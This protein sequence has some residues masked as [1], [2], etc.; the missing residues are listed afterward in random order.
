LDGGRPDT[1]SRFKANGDSIC[2]DTT[3]LIRVLGRKTGMR[4]SDTSSYAYIRMGKTAMPALDKPDS[5]WF[6]GRFCFTFSDATPGAH[7]QYTLDGSDPAA[8][9]IHAH[10]GDS[11]CVDR[12]VAVRLIAEAPNSIPSD[13]N[14]YRYFRMDTAAAPVS[15]RAD[16]TWFRDTLCLVLSSATPGAVIHYTVDGSRPDTA[17]PVAPAGGFCVDRSSQVRAIAVLKHWIDSPVSAYTYAKMGIL[18]PPAATPSDSSGFPGSLC[19]HF[20]TNADGAALRYSLDGSDPSGSSLVM[21]MSDSLCFDSTVAIRARAE[22]THW[23]PSP[24]AA[25]TY[26]RM[27]QVARPTA[28]RSDSTWFADTLCV[29]FAIATDSATLHYLLGPGRTDT[30]SLLIAPGQNLCLDRGAVVRV[31]GTRPG[32]L[33]S[34]ELTLRFFKMDTAAVPTADPGDSTWFAGRQCIRLSTSTAGAGIRYTVD[35]G[36]PAVSGRAL[37]SGDTVCIEDTATLRV[38]ARGPNRVD[39]RE[40]VFHYLRMRKVATPS[41]DRRD[42]TFFA[43]TVCVRFGTAT[44]GAT[45]RYT[46]DGSAPDTA[47]PV[48]AGGGPLCVDRT[49]V[50][51]VIGTKEHWIPSDPMAIR[52]LKMDTVARPVPEPGDSTYFSPSLCVKWTVATPGAVI[53]VTTDGA[54]PDSSSRLLASGDTLCLDRTATLRAAGAKPDWIASPE[55]SAAFLRMQRAAK[56]AADQPDSLYFPDRVCIRFT[57]A[58]AGTRIRYALDG[59]RADTSGLS[60]ANGDSVC[61]ERS[62]RIE[63]VAERKN[64]LAS[65]ALSLNVFRMETA[66]IPVAGVPDSTWFR[67]RICV[68]WT[69]ATPGAAITVR[70]AFLDSAGKSAGSGPDSSGQALASGDSV[71]LDR[72]ASLRAVASLKH[73]QD[74]PAALRSYFRMDTVAKPVFDLRDTVF[75]PSICARVSSGTPGAVIRYTVDGGDPDTSSLVKPGGDTLCTDRSARIRAIAERPHSVPSAEASLRLDKMAQVAPLKASIGDSVVFARRICFTLS[76][77]TDSVRIRY[78]LGGDPLADTL[79][80]RSGDSVCLERSAVVV[81]V[82]TRPLW[83]NSPEVRISLEVDNEGPRLVKAEKRPFD[84]QNLPVTG[85]CRG[86][87]QDTLKVAFSERLFPKSK[88]PRWDRLLRFSPSCDSGDG[89]PVEPAGDPVVSGDGL[90]A[91]LL[92]DNA[93]AD[94]K[95][96][97]GNCLSLDWKSGEFPDRVGNPPERDGVRIEGREGASHISQIRAYPPVVGLDDAGAS[98]GCSD[99]RVQVNTWIPPA[100]FDPAS[101]TIDPGQA[102]TCRETGGVSGSRAAIPPCLSIVEVVS[103][104]PYVADVRIFDQM[105]HFVQGSRQ[106]FGACGELDDLERSVAGKKRSYLVWNNRDR[107]GARVGNGAYVWR[108]R[109]LTGK[110]GGQEMQTVLLRTGFLRT[111]ACGD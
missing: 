54:R 77:A 41:A 45:L 107:A 14:R 58:T 53:R 62:A 67:D 42:S 1:S 66:A 99:E 48:L 47:S 87:G 70:T 93:S 27:P 69:T 49:A 76:S 25:F 51:R 29:R 7:I 80:M 92:L 13:E 102:R 65:E 105:G 98:G 90:E 78:S 55:A 32:W 111:G 109:F 95:P 10:A 4:D 88:P 19:V 43:D 68:P 40:A 71:C 18:A 89:L 28:S 85:N 97:L 73:W 75:Y 86:I 35:G 96:K 26:R 64:W 79:S 6:T 104:G 11:L 100:G 94:E 72:S 56:P 12:T 106:Q 44:P 17:S 2:L 81:A 46:V 16:S 34:P 50:L 82:G 36:D 20:S 9:D 83:R 57:S 31:A 101:G 110:E 37:F 59:G 39:S 52:A 84:I 24:A 30:S 63:A 8:V 33:P 5:T 3:R 61:L 103:D 23:I 60:V 15:N 91:T 38:L 108:I 21:P 22:K 74:S